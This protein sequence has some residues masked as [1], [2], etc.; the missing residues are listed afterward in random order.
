VS[1]L[2]KIKTF[3]NYWLD[4][5]DEHSLHSPFLYDFYSNVV[6]R[7]TGELVQI[8][9]LRKQLLK[10]DRE[11]WINDFGSGSKHMA[12][13]NRKIS[14][15]AFYSLS[16]ARFSALYLRMTAYAKAKTII[17]LGTAF[18]INT[19]YLSQQPHSMVYTFE[20]SEAISEI[21]E[22][23]FEFAG[24]K[25]IELIKGNLDSTLYATLSRIPKV[26]LAFIDANH[27]LDATLRY[28]ELLLSKSHDKSIFIIDDIHDSP[29]M[30]KAWNEIRKHQLV[31]TSVD[32]FQCG[33]LFFDPSLNKQ[34]VVLRF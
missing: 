12:G 17:E 32:L 6:N 11:I 10:D 34:H 7:E 18:G 4:A 13:A 14:D 28:F 9:G 3:F 29:G 2:F 31:Y 8:E 15:I 5:V 33:V 20:G 21:A 23:S 25:N 1:R 22:L 24:A 30:E 19:L 26:D 27:R 16:Q